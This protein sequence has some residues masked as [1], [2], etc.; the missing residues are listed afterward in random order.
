MGLQVELVGAGCRWL[1]EK[2]LFKEW[3]ALAP[4]FSCPVLLGDREAACWAHHRRHGP[5]RPLAL[6]AG[7]SL[8]AR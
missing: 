2:L 7:F 4:Q 5:G 1:L 6:A 8:F 3:V